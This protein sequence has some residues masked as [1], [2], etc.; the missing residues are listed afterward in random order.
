MKKTLLILLILLLVFA[1]V[2]ITAQGA[3]SDFDVTYDLA[4]SSLPY[5]GGTMR[6]TINVYNNG[7]SNITWVDAIV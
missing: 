5:K 3:D 4:F 1:A 6:I 7:S 2:P